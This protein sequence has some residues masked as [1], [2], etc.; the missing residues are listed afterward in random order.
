MDESETVGRRDAIAGLGLIGLLLVSLVGTIFYRIVAP[1]A[2]R[3][4]PPEIATLLAPPADESLAA[5]NSG[6]TVA[7]EHSR[8][9]NEDQDVRPATLA[10]E[11]P[12]N[13]REVDNRPRFIAPSD[14]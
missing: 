4:I 9:H 11:S 5:N 1:P 12:G 3:R 2:P 14:R 6:D 10:V 13:P 7:A 8:S